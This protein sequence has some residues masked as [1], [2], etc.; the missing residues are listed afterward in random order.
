MLKG[1]TTHSPG[2]ST[3]LLFFLRPYSSLQKPHSIPFLQ[4]R[5]CLLHLTGSQ[6]F[7]KC[8]KFFSSNPH[9]RKSQPEQEQEEAPKSQKRKNQ[10]SPTS[11]NSLRRVAV[12]AQS[13]RNIKEATREGGHDP[14][15]STK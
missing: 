6:A 5:T 9:L 15:P 14:Q 7:P 11:K 13:S 2:I 8:R 3:T 10:R 1:F 12:E 4:S